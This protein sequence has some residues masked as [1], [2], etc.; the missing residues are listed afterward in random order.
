MT[1]GHH[2]LVG[3]YRY[4]IPIPQMAMNRFPFTALAVI[5]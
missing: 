3:R 1:T 4:E 2:E 5:P